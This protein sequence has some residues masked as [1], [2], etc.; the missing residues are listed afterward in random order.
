[1]DGV[2]CRY[3]RRGPGKEF[4]YQDRGRLEKRVWSVRI[5]WRMRHGIKDAVFAV[6]FEDDISLN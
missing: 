4:K 1:M 6:G 2:W 5:S 3:A